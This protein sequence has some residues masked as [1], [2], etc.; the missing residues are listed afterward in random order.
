MLKSC[1]PLDCFSLSVGI[2]GILVTVHNTALTLL[3]SLGFVKGGILMVVTLLVVGVCGMN[4]HGIQVSKLLSGFKY[5]MNAW[6]GNTLRIPPNLL[7][8]DLS[9]VVY[10]MLIGLLSLVNKL[11]FCVLTG[12]IFRH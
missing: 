9:H 3:S 2:V 4:D 5:C 7:S 11:V 10:R 8:L 6:R 12:C 1:F